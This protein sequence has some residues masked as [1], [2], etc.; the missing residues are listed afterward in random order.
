MAND[1]HRDHTT[2][3][4]AAEARGGSVSGRVNTVHIISGVAAFVALI[5]I[6]IIYAFVLT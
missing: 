6:W 4:T 3:R 5:L 2:D 1:E